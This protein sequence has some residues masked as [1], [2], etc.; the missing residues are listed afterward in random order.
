M[1]KLDKFGSNVPIKGLTPA[2]AIVQQVL[3]GS[4]AGG[5]AFEEIKNGKPDFK[6][7]TTAQVVVTPAVVK[8]VIIAA[9]TKKGQVLK[10]ADPTKGTPEERIQDEE[11]PQ[12]IESR[13]I[14][15]AVMRDRTEAEELQR[16]RAKYGGLTNKK[17]TNLLGLIFG[18]GMSVKLP[19]KFSELDFNKISYNGLDVST[20][21]AG[22]DVTK[23]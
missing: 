1:V 23:A 6:D 2:E 8:N 21:L 15:T 7:I 20:V 22:G 11:I 16:L 17:S 9:H 4:N 10:P 18:T 13:V 19:Q 12:T 3:H 14:T 5:T